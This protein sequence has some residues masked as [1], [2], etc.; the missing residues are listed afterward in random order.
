MTRGTIKTNVLEEFLKD[1]ELF[2]L[3]LHVS[4]EVFKVDVRSVGPQMW[5]KTASHHWY[6]LIH[7][8]EE[9]I[10][11]CKGIYDNS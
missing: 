4:G 6:T 9:R 5:I 8:I 1:G 11:L 10:M 2:L 7:Q 3:L